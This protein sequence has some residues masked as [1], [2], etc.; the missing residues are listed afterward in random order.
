M[1]R[2]ELTNADA[3]PLEVVKPGDEIDVYVLSPNDGEG[4]VELSLV[5]VL[6]IKEKEDIKE[7]FKSLTDSKEIRISKEQGISRQAVN[8]K[9]HK[10]KEKVKS[11]FDMK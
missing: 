6:A 4:Y 2:E 10:N 7:I 11:F 5:R 8:V 1:T 3:S 9:I